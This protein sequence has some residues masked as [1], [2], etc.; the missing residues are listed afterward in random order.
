MRTANERRQEIIEILCEKRFVK[1][2]YLA[3]IFGVSRQ[4][5]CSDIAI[6]TASYP[7]ETKEG[8]TGGVY[9][10]D[11]YYIGKQYL[12]DEQENVLRELTGTVNESQAMILQSILSKFGKPKGI[13]ER[14]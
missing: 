6:L 5:I 11:G 12:T 2:D 9:L 4:T 14:K 7:L 10:A 3:E 1:S 8:K 13:G